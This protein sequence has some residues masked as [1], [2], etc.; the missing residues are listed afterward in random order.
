ML[1]GPGHPDWTRLIIGQ[2]EDHPLG[3]LNMSA[4]ERM[5]HMLG[6]RLK[7]WYT[8]ESTEYFDHHVDD[9]HSDIP[10]CSYCQAE[11]GVH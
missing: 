1:I 4:M 10:G 2:Y 11:S 9:H 6:P 7:K 8:P 3:L 5:S